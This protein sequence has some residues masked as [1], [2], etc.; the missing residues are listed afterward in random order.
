MHI[1][2]RYCI[3]L[4]LGL[5]LWLASSQS[6]LAQS[7]VKPPTMEDYFQ[8][9]ISVQELS[10]QEWTERWEIATTN[11]GS[12]LELADAWQTVMTKYQQR[13]EQLMQDAGFGAR[14][15]LEYSRIYR[16]EMESYLEEHEEIQMRIQAL[17]SQINGL[18]QQVEAVASDREGGVRRSSRN[19]TTRTQLPGRIVSP[20]SQ[21]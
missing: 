5:L 7:E 11:K 9:T 8:L 6:A 10:V 16:A 21:P 2:F 3:W 13:R 14:L 20:Q 19:P 4:G 1:H 12:R 18:I 17:R 15:Y